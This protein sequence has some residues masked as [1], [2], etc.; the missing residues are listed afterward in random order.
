MPTVRFKG[1]V[2]PETQ[3]ISIGPKP[4]IQWQ[5][6]AKNLSM[7]FICNIENSLVD[8]QCSLNRWEEE[9]LP[10]LYRRALDLSRASVELV[11]FA[12]GCAL[13]VCLDS[14]I[15][16]EGIEK[17]LHLEDQSLSALCTA[18]NLECDFDVVQTLVLQEPGLFMALHDLIEAISIPHASLVNCAR[19]VERIKHLLASTGQSE[20][21]AWTTMRTT[22]MIDESYIL[23]VTDNSKDSRHG[24]GSY[25]DGTVTTEVT[26]RA[27]SIL[28][29]YLHYK[30]N[31]DMLPANT[32]NL[33]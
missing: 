23:Y 14:F 7:D 19:C 18:F 26:R 1:R 10:D 3:K 13:S 30:K 11:G 20:K 29:R 27:W 16:H 9:F 8:I 33:S 12:K 32:S 24:R 28:D 2:L 5:E 31:G 22:S 21:Q 4:N 17:K 25:V 15:D 6:T